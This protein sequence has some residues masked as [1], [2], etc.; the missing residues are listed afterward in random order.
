MDGSSVVIM[1]PRPSPRPSP[2]PIQATFQTW[3]AQGRVGG[4]SEF[5]IP[6]SESS[7]RVALDDLGVLDFAQDF[8]ATGE[9]DLDLAF[10]VSDDD[11]ALHH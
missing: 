5:R 4:N 3:E 9:D 1:K 2:C 11:V 8:A 6:N 10:G 7:L